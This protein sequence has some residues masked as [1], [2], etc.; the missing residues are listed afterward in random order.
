V[1]TPS[2]S[3]SSS[4]SAWFDARSGCANRYYIGLSTAV[5]NHAAVVHDPCSYWFIMRANL[6]CG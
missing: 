5:L 2:S 1:E 6:C 3:S 4:S